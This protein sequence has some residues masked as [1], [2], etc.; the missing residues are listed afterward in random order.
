MTTKSLPQTLLKTTDQDEKTLCVCNAVIISSLALLTFP[1]SFILCNN[2]LQG[3]ETGNQICVSL[4]FTILC[5]RC[6]VTSAGGGLMWLQPPEMFKRFCMK[7][8]FTTVIK[9]LWLQ[10]YCITTQKTMK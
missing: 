3:Q 9:K 4:A 10:K 5:V 6:S 7:P 2:N 8:F 1:Y